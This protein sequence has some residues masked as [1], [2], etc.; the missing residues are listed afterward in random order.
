MPKRARDCF[1]QA[2]YHDYLTEREYV[3]V[4]QGV[5]PDGRLCI[6][7]LE[8]SGKPCRYYKFKE[9]GYIL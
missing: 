9:V 5:E 3:G 4:I 6:R 7:D 8:A 1:P 2:H